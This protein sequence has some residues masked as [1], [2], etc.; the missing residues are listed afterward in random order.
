MSQY[1]PYF[2]FWA[3]LWHHKIDKWISA[4]TEMR[5]SIYSR[6]GKVL[7]PNAGRVIPLDVL[8]F[9]SQRPK[10]EAALAVRWSDF[11]GSKTL[12]LLM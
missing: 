6:D 11:G 9:D 5:H 1:K 10:S 7:I 3:R 12:L 4:S 2:S 8:F